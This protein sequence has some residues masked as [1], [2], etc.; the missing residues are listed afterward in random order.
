[1]AS[2]QTRRAAAREVRSR[3]PVPHRGQPSVAGSQ[4]SRRSPQARTTAVSQA[5][6]ESFLQYYLSLEHGSETD[7]VPAAWRRSS[8]LAPSSL[9]GLSSFNYAL[10]GLLLCALCMMEPQRALYSGEQL[11]AAL[12]IWQGFISFKCDAVDLGIRSWSHPVDRISATVFTLV[13]V[14]KYCFMECIGAWGDAIYVSLSIF[15]IAGLYCF[16]RSCQACRAHDLRGYRFWHIA[17]HFAF[18]LAMAFFYFCQFLAPA[19]AVSCRLGLRTSARLS[20]ESVTR[21]P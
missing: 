15:L 19:E 8:L 4:K 12:W 20:R 1:M 3:S 13:L 17:W 10:V 2:A 11:E 7:K 5:P 21:D 18:P 14:V 6:K 9:Y 16:R